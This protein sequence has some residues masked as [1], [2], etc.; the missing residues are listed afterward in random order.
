MLDSPVSSARTGLVCPSKWT[1]P[2][3]A[4]STSQAQI[5]APRGSG[6]LSLSVATVNATDL[7]KTEAVATA[8]AP[9]GNLVQSGCPC[10]PVMR[11]TW[12]PTTWTGLYLPN[13]SLTRASTSSQEVGAPATSVSGLAVVLPVLPGSHELNSALEQRLQ[14]VRPAVLACMVIIM[15]P[16]RR[17]PGLLGAGVGMA[18][19][20]LTHSLPTSLPDKYYRVNLRTKQV[21]TVSPPY[22]RNIAQ[23]WLGCPA[24]AL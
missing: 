14:K 17:D 4:R 22:P 1:Q 19:L 23:Y 8:R 5:W 12:E 21:D 24:P 6:T 18:R 13:A 7:A 3:L 11:V 2:W 20:G 10:S 16:S 15:Y 9:T